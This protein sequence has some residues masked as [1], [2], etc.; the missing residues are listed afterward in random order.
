M[1]PNLQQLLDTMR[2]VNIDLVAAINAEWPAG[3]W[4]KAST[5]HPNR[6]P[7][8][9]RVIGAHPDRPGYLAAEFQ[10]GHRTLVWC[11]S[12]AGPA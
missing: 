7:E 6:P 9:V 4:I 11:G 1:T 8:L 10:S 2:Q 12:V 3:T 5:S